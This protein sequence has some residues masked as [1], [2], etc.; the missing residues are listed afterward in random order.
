MD[1]EAVSGSLE[2]CYILSLSCDLPALCIIGNRQLKYPGYSSMTVSSSV[3][4]SSTRPSKHLNTAVNFM[5]SQDLLDLDLVVY[6]KTEFLGDE[7]IEI[8]HL[9]SN[10]AHRRM[11]P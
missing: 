6:M 10:L 1:H 9:I 11:P 5:S 8:E 2:R 3:S 7:L 4:P